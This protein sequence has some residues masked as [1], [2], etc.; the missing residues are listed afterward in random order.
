MSCAL[1][2]SGLVGSMFKSKTFRAPKISCDHCS[3]TIE[4]ELGKLDG[5]ETVGADAAAKVVTVKWNEPPATWDAIC[6]KLAEIN[7][8]PAP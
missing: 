4:R 7:F 1:A 2:H 5:V 3:R 8:P 6:S